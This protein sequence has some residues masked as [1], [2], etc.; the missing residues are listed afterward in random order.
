M[1]SPNVLSVLVDRKKNIR[2]EMVAYR[3]LAGN[4]LVVAVRTAISMM[5]RKPKKNSTY[6]FITV[7]GA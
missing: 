4:E 6:R 7:F 5:K 1:E 3:V 2:Y